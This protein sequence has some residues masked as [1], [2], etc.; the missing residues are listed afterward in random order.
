MKNKMT[1]EDAIMRLEDIT[2]ILESGSADL[3]SSVKL[4]EEALELVKLCNDKIDCAEQ[5]VKL[6]F[7]ADDGTICEKDFK[8]QNED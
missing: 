8:G 3:D 6:L 2:R 5:K 1:F 7:E 4:Y